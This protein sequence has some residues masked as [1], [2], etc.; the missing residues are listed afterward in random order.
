VT[1]SIYHSEREK[2]ANLSFLQNETMHNTS[3]ASARK[4]GGLLSYQELFFVPKK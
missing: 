4:T 2:A 1:I 3:A